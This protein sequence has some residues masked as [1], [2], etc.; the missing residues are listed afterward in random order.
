MLDNERIVADLD[1]GE[2]A[3]YYCAGFNQETIRQVFRDLQ[4]KLF[5]RYPDY[6]L[7]PL[8][9]DEPEILLG[10]VPTSLELTCLTDDKL[11]E[12][13]RLT[14]QILVAEVGADGPMN[15]EDVALKAVKEIQSLKAEVKRLNSLLSANRLL[16]RVAIHNM[17]QPEQ[18]GGYIY[19]CP[20]PDEIKPV[21]AEPTAAQEREAIVAR[22]RYMIR[23]C[24][25]EGNV[26]SDPLWTEHVI[27]L[28]RAIETIERGEHW[29]KGGGN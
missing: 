28:R 20:Q 26:A 9:K 10:R 14:A 15:A 24:Y 7:T 8:G 23:E 25:A 27:A 17:V 3:F 11:K 13:L 4:G 29:P 16:T 18:V 22:L 1:N 12:R 19:G 6:R 21:K 2:W 5:I